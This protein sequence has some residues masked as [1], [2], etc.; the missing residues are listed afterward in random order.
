MAKIHVI[1]GAVLA[2]T[3]TLSDGRVELTG[4]G[5]VFQQG[6]DHQINCFVTSENFV[7]WKTPAKP[8]R[9]GKEAIPSENIT[10]QTT[11]GRRTIGR[12][13]NNY[14]L[15]ITAM[16]ADD[17]G[18]YECRGS[19]EY[20]I[21]NV[22]VD[23]NF[24]LNLEA[25]NV[26]LGDHATIKFGVSSYPPA[27]YSWVKDGQ[28]LTFNWRRELDAY[29]GNIMLKPV[30]LEDEG[31]YTCTVRY[32]SGTQPFNTFA[33]NVVVS[34]IINKYQGEPVKRQLTEGY[35]VTFHC[36]IKSGKPR[37]T[38]TWYYTWNNTVKKVDRLY[39]PRMSH[40]TDEE[41]TITGVQQS[42]KGRYRCIA[43]NIAG[44]DDLRFEIIGVDVPPKIDPIPDILV[45]EGED[46]TLECKASG[47]PLLVVEWYRHGWLLRQT[48]GTDGQKSVARISLPNIRWI[49]GG[50]YTCKA[51]NGALDSNG[52]EVVTEEST[53]VNVKSP[54]RLISSRD[55]VYTFI[56]NRE[57]TSVLCEF[58]GYPVP[59]VKMVNENGTEVATGNGSALFVIQGTKSEEVFG[60]YNCSAVNSLG[61]EV[62]L[63][64]LRVAVLPG[65][66]RQ[67]FANTTCKDVSIQWENPEDDGGMPVTNYVITLSLRGAT[68]HEETVDGSRRKADI[69]YDSFEAETP[70]MVDLMAQNAVGYSDKESVAAT[71]KTFCVPGKPSIKNTEINVGSSF[72]LTWTPPSYNGGDDNIKY[73]VEWR[74]KPINED[75]VIF[76]EDNIAAEQLIIKDLEAEAKYEFRVYAENQAGLSEPDIRSFSVMETT[77]TPSEDPGQIPSGKATFQ[78][79]SAAPTTILRL[80]SGETTNLTATK[81][82]GPNVKGA[83]GEEGIGAGAIAGIV[84]AVILIV[85]ITIDLF[86]CFFNSCGFIFCC[87]QVLC[88]KSAA[89]KKDM[90]KVT[91]ATEMEK[92][93]LPES[94]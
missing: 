64:E 76:S 80:S 40:P 90:Y 73:K 67:V 74:K 9:P 48:L 65:M 47:S 54:P 88:G 32:G 60:E 2:M 43:E 23:F 34:P 33:V 41:W 69:N 55:P 3:V 10:L 31:N 87:H 28:P 79:T 83:S 50:I 11:T 49:D 30:G 86:C 45:N 22:S 14:R 92:K 71:T 85:L 81:A 24:I 72:T 19:A 18:L 68:L 38:I 44:K 29:T 58:S 59:L 78:T 51:K 1:I 63:L 36:D 66:P 4:Q 5:D 26:R 21:Y 25:Q 82:T 37:P 52:R 62:A 20:K 12:T 17:G 16:T 94:V 93:P 46:V 77:E 8:A 70:Y 7:A 27:S 39:D 6:R 42:D 75:T 53:S 15:K 84:I 91:N 61:N 89:K 13:G 57:N 56:G 35:N